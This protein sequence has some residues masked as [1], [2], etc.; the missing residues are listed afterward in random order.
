ML[1]VPTFVIL[2]AHRPMEPGRDVFAMG[3]GCSIEDVMLEAA[4]RADLPVA[5]FATAA[6]ILDDVVVPRSQWALVRP[7]PGQQLIINL[8][9][10]L[11]ALPLVFAVAAAAAPGALGLAAGS[12][13]AIA[14]SAGI[15]IVGALITMA[16]SPT[17]RIRSS[18][19]DK[20]ENAVSS[21]QGIGNE[22]RP[23][24]PVPRIFG[25]LV[26]YYPKRCTNYY[27]E[28]SP[29]NQ[30]FMRVVFCFGDG[31]LRFSDLKI[32]TTPVTDFEG[33][34]VETRGGYDTD[35]PL[36]LFPAQVREQSLSIE[37]RQT[38][39]FSQR[40]SEIDSDEIS[41]DVVF[42]GGLQRIGGQNAKFNLEV[43]FEI[44]Y[45]LAA[46]ANWT[47]A[48]LESDGKNL[49]MSGPGR[50]TI[51]GNTKVALRRAV[52]VVLP[53]R[54]RYDVRIRRLTTDDQATN[55]G[56]NQ[57]VT[58]EAAYWTALRSHRNE[59][60]FTL[61]DTAKIALRIRASEQLQ[62]V[63]DQFNCTVEA[64][65]PVWNGATW[66]STFT[67]SPAWAFCEVLRGNSHARPVA[68]SRIDLAQM[69]AFDEYCTEE[70]IT[71]DAEFAD[72]ESVYDILEDIANTANASLTLADGLFS[73]VIDN[74]R[75]TPIQHFTER[76]SWGFA[77]SKVLARRPHAVKYRFPN[78]RT[79]RQ[80]D[81]GY[82]YEP[83]YDVS[84]ATL[85]ETIDL[86]YTTSKRQAYLRA[87]RAMFAARL[88]PEIY[89]LTVGAEH[90]VCT[91]GDLVRVVH[92]V[93]LLGI[94]AA[95]VTARTTSGAN[96][97]GVT[98][99]APFVMT[100]GTSYALRFRQSDG[101]SVLVPVNTVAGSQDTFT[102]TTAVVTASGPAVGDLALFGELGTE[103]VEMIVRSV[104]PAEDLTARITLVDYSAEIF[105]SGS[106]TLPNFDPQITIPAVVNR[107]F[108]AP[109]SITSI[110]SDEAVL[111][112][113]SDGTLTAR[114][115]LGLSVDNSSAEVPAEEFQVRY[116]PAET[117]QDFDFVGTFPATVGSVSI[118]PVDEGTTYE[119]EVRTRFA[120]APSAWVTIEHLV[121]GKTG[122]PPDVER[123]Y[124]QGD[125][126]TWP[127]PDPPVDL[128]GFL[129]RANYGTSTDWSTGRPLHQGIVSAPPFDISALHGAQVIMVKA[130]DTSG[131]E[132]AAAA[133]VT[134]HLGDL[135]VQ[136]VIDTQSEAPG[137]SGTITGGTDVGATLEADLLSSPVFW[138]ADDA[139]WWLAAGADFW[140]TNVYDE[141]TYTASWTP[142]SDQLTDGILLVDVTV[143]GDYT[144]DYRISMSAVFWGAG[145]SLHWGTAG[146]DYWSADEVGEFTTWPGQLGPFETTANTYQ[147]RITVAGG[148]TQGVISQ[149]DLIC[150][151]PDIEEL[152]KDQVITVAAT[153][154]RLT[155]AAA[156]RAIDVVTLTLQQ[157][158]G[159]AVTL[160]IIDKNATTGS[161]IKAYDA[162][163]AVTTATFDA[164]TKAH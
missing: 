14:V 9:P 35:T 4:H 1:P 78:E 134:T 104:E 74:E 83:G 58:I 20:K 156:R 91:R 53:A 85:F 84:T 2:V 81:E 41:L 103:S 97:T 28:L 54:G 141:M 33:V 64:A 56:K 52:R 89:S 128:A 46:S 70:G 45:K 63:V 101:D 13:A 22:A 40:R 132:S 149:M 92:S 5:R 110:A 49:T 157:D 62:G 80:Y 26:N 17:P 69:I 25:R 124:R 153:G 34:T 24:G 123:L 12:L 142:A 133:T 102:F 30:Q 43:E 118:V 61:T 51:R 96:T 150:D 57:T 27:T 114:I 75:D 130:V 160:K 161:L 76:N 154:V 37:L 50:F 131:F 163:G 60:P 164:R 32:G 77:S 126:I 145:G 86:P 39:G 88:R 10:G 158:G 120:G 55:E 82:V 3:Q 21:I 121:I 147:V 8:V 95:R 68:D 23:Y 71:F 72:Q 152:Y 113:A 98:L 19:P 136:N 100:G 18:A 108:P 94:G 105:T 15:S 109:P 65:L 99:D 11:P 140:Q 119:I 31:P 155:P 162:A 93:P 112:R 127:Y 117:D 115:V 129:I 159:T 137:F 6:A 42:P 29:G 47:T 122:V 66:T 44:E 135:Y 73:V 151:V 138:R 48:T 106:G 111:V 38:N 7:C 107:G 36:T 139:L 67:R 143:V 59:D 87:R 116:R 90:L 16:L 125:A 144:I 148:T 146:D 79:L